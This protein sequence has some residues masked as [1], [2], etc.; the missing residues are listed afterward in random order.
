MGTKKAKQPSFTISS[1]KYRGKRLLLPLSEK[2]RPT[3]SIIRGSVFDTLQHEIEGTVFVE[4]FGGSGSMGL[5]ALSRGADE[6]WFF[7]KDR[8]ALR[9]LEQN[10]AAL[11]S[12]R[13]HVIAGDSFTHYPTLIARLANEGKRAFIYFDPP[14]AIREGMG[15]IYERVSALIEE[16]PSEVVHKII[17]EHMHS[18]DFADRIGPFAKEKTKRFGKTA[19]TYYGVA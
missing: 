19:L 6:V 8:T 17:I 3:K 1:G 18:V 12:G 7:E 9:Q 5:E 16:T 10:C 15:D 14:F 2:T 4:L 13:T 11:D